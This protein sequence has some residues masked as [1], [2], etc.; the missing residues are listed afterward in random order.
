MVLLFHDLAGLDMYS[1][2]WK[3]LCRKGWENDFEYFQIDRFATLG[4]GRYTIRYCY[5]TTHTECTRK[6]KLF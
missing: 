3:Q 2:E 5:K 6:T 1:E 4:E